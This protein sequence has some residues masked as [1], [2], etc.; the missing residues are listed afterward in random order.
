MNILGLLALLLFCGSYSTP[1]QARSSDEEFLESITSD[2]SKKPGVIVIVHLQGKVEL[3]DETDSNLGQAKKGDRLTNGMKIVTASGAIADL[4]FSNGFIMQLQENSRFDVATFSHEPYEFVFINGAKLNARDLDKFAD[5]KAIIS[6]LE[7]SEDAWNDLELEP[8]TSDN[9]FILHYGTMIG[10]TKRLKPGSRMDIITPIGTAGIRGTIWRLTVIPSPNGDAGGT[11]YS[12][13]LDVSRGRVSFTTPDGTRS[14]NVNNGF[15]AQIEASAQGADVSIISLV[16]SRLTPERIVLLNSTAESTKNDQDAFAAVSTRSDVIDRVLDAVANVDANDSPAFSEAVSN[17][18]KS[19]TADAGQIAQVATA[20]ALVRAGRETMPS[21]IAETNS[22][23]IRAVPSA[24]NAITSGTVKTASNSGMNQGTINNVNSAVSQSAI[25]TGVSLGSTS[26]TA[27]SGVV[28]ALVSNSPTNANQI[29][30]QALTAVANS[31]LP[32]TTQSNLAS[33]VAQS[34]IQASAQSALQS[35]ANFNSAAQTAAATAQA[36]QQSANNLGLGAAV[37]PVTT[38]VSVENLTTEAQ[39]STT[40]GRGTSTTPNQGGTGDSNTGDTTET[41]NPGNPG[42]TA[43]PSQGSTGGIT[44]PPPRPTPTPKLTP[45]PP[46][47]P[48]PR[49]SRR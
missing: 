19:N 6:N 35:G 30:Q 2:D 42:N 7:A 4:A 5:E 33:S 24:S 44:G 29:S 15:S 47:T 45:T 16:T 48:T 26:P 18:A 28:G 46:P 31:G 3:L 20:V 32:A 14:V 8:V 17:L 9:E 1:A 21:V 49:P 13:T 40:S 11:S 36:V 12:G 38:P 43:D 41:P 27:L 23:L 25:Q 39:N 37:A 34:T 22:A 10:E